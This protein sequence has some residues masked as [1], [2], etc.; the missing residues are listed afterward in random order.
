MFFGG[1]EL[2]ETKVTTVASRPEMEVSLAALGVHV[3]S[4][5]VSAAGRLTKRPA[6]KP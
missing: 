4:A 2:V 6:L 3:G 5:V 1:F